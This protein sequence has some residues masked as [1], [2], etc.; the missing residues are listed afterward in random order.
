VNHLFFLLILAFG[1]ASYVVGLKE[2]FQ[3]KYSPSVFSRVVWLL[4]AAASFAGVLS[5]KSTAAS[6]LLSGIFLLGNAA[7]CLVSFWRGTKEVGKL[8]FICL[9][10]L[11]TSGV[12][13]LVFKAPLVSLGFSLLAHFVGG[14][15]TYRK[16]W[17]HPENESTGFWSLFFLASAFSVVA[18]HG[19]SVSLIIF[20]IYFTLFDG[21]M[22]FL[23]L[24]KGVKSHT[25][26]KGKDSLI[27]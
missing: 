21:S 18:S 26:A 23:S 8:E 13:W 2:M 14:A 20:P 3:G 6:A 22:T 24:R 27:A 4:L 10:I 7:I 5:S 25:Q 15:P 9:A 16:V 11:V 17:K 12:I 19:D 1:T